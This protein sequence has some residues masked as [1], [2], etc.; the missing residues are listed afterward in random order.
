M[1]NRFR[2][3]A[4]FVVV[5]IV[6]I[7]LTLVSCDG[8]QSTA[9]ANSQTASPAALSLGKIAYVLDGS[10]YVKPLPDGEATRIADGTSP[11]WSPSGDWLLYSMGGTANSWV[12]RA[13][14]SDSRDLSGDSAV[15]SPT[16]DR[17]A[18]YEGPT[19]RNPSTSLRVESADGSIRQEAWLIAQPESGPAWSPD[20]KRLAYTQEGS[21]PC[22]MAPAYDPNAARRS[23][24]C[25]VNAD[26]S[27]MPRVWPI[28]LYDSTS[29]EL[30]VAGWT[31]DSQYVLFWLDPEFANSAMNDGLPL[32]AVPAAGGPPRKL[33]FSLLSGVWEPSP[34]GGPTILM[35]EGLGR[36][37]WTRERIALAN[38]AT[39]EITYLT[40]QDMASQQPDWSPDGQRIVFVSQPDI[41]EGPGGSGSELEKLAADRQIWV[42]G[43]DG[44]NLRQLTNEPSY[45][46]EA[47]HWS[48]D[49][50]QILFARLD[51]Q[52]FASLWMMNADG[53]DPKEVVD[54]IGS[55][56]EPLMGYYG[57]IGWSGWFNWWRP[58]PPHTT[59]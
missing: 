44:G 35:T 40:G 46:D 13:D 28:D 47:P 43:A 45:R 15:W 30:I 56:S 21:V 37:T 23:S 1:R 18:Y 54:R 9:G 58:S 20:G 22:S 6:T 2:V 31:A 52:R 7:S 5:A 42:M 4:P 32:Y 38:A 16:E 19:G 17:F 12:V 14:G 34:T 36:E 51:E 27:Q 33:T 50:S 59:R 39:G 8:R 57:N 29:D 26:N 49:G 10:I 25:V 48:A 41:G 3:G 24:L 55:S 53:S 11:R